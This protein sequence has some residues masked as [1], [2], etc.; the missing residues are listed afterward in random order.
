MT[1][2]ATSVPAAYKASTARNA[3]FSRDHNRE[4]GNCGCSAESYASS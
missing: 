3:Y 4:V 1:S 2:E